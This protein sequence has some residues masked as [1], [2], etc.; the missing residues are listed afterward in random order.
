MNKVI[1]LLSAVLSISWVSA[2]VGSVS[3][4][5]SPVAQTQHDKATVSG[6]IMYLGMHRDYDHGNH[7]RASTLGITLNVQSPVWSGIDM[8]LG[9][10]Y[11]ESFL[12]GGNTDLL[13]NDEINVL[14][15]AWLRYDLA[16]IG[17]KKTHFI[18]GRK[19]S[20]G[21]VFRRDDY[22]QKAR[23]IEAL[24]LTSQ[25]L[26]DTELT[27][28]HASKMSNWIDAGDCWDFNNFGDV[29]GMADDTRGVTWVDMLY[30]GIKR[31]EVAV[32]DAYAWDVSNLIGTRIR[33]QLCKEASLTAYYRHEGNLGDAPRQSSN[34]YGISYHQDIGG[35]TIETGYWGVSGDALR[36]QET[37]TGINHALGCS[38]MLYSD[39]F[40]GDSNTLYIKATKKIGKTSAYLLYHYTWQDQKSYDGQEI[41][42]VL[43]Y[44]IGENFS[45]TFKGGVGCRD[46]RDGVEDT[47]ATDARLFLTY[48]F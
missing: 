29:F 17:M 46:G 45:A 21:E 10:N 32:Y 15:E 19:I 18:A 34:A 1:L 5:D 14:N 4:T 43:K 28:G 37:T 7:G 2:D 33:Y 47:L 20:H 31:W 22:R 41:D 3:N 44:P 26:P 12:C 38:M 9:Y 40:S 23:A 30:T 8:G 42:L 25:G 6:R 36:F 48:T 27:V 13:C 16:N 39:Q 35:G 11:A 24:Q